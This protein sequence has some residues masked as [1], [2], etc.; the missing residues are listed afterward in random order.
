M[1]K[2]I[3]KKYQAFIRNYLLSNSLFDFIFAYA[4]YNVLFNIRGLSVLEISILIAFWALSAMLLEIPSG[5]LADYWSRKKMLVIAPLIK[6]L[7]FITWFLADG[8]FYLYA[9]GF[10]FW[11]LASSFVSGT[12]EALLYD[13]L[14]D[15]GK[16]RDYEKI[17][18]KKK[19]Y[20]YIA[21]AVST[22]LGGI[23][24]HY[25]LDW[26]LIFSIIPLFLSSFFAL[27]IEETPKKGS[28]KEINYLKYIKIAYQEVKNN[29]ILKILLLYAFGI[30]IL[31]DLEEFDQLYYQLVNLP[32]Y[33]FGIVGFIWSM[34]NAIGAFYA[35]KLK[36]HSWVFYIFPFI[37]ASFIFLVG[38]KPSIPILGLLLISYFVNS[39]LE[40]L[41]NGKIQHNIKTLGR[42]TITSVNTFFI[43]FLGAIL[44]LIFG[45]ISKI[46]NL[47]AIYISTGIFLFIFGVWAVIRRRS[48][49]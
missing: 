18:S 48:F 30:S 47:Q 39:P 13:E 44:T 31:G 36:N 5:A 40:V 20:F 29:K 49:Y 22:V 37:S 45:L 6:S 3:N 17:L 34:L 4:I 33:A 38:L 28:T 25:N 15:F 24:A 9:L 46:W 11:S 7:C 26:A 27:L 32:L 1:Q 8:N 41:I 16:K 43:S 2:A 21:L 23:I 12:T 35:Y 10:L 42:A 19:F 14:I